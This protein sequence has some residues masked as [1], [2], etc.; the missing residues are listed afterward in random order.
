MGLFRLY[1]IP[2][3]MDP[4]LGT[5]VRYAADEL[6]AIVTLESQRARAVVVGE[7]LGTVEE[8]VRERLATHRLLSYR[9]LWF[10]ADPPAR[11]PE[12][13]LAAV[14]THDLPTVAG[15]WSGADLRTQQRLG[16]RPNE[17]GLREIA[18][19]LRAMTGLPERAQV[20]EVIVR[21]HQLLAEA[22]SV[23]VTA[24]LEDA[25]AVEERPNMPST[26]AEWPNWSLALPTPLED[27]ETQPLTQAVADTLRRR[28]SPQGRTRGSMGAP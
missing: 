14:T 25:L 5:Y 6:L 24:T 15:L 8:E 19:R 13:A 12:L 23:V 17:A 21:A 3:G 28:S 16:L 27:L 2:Q 11:Y 10:E 1:W 20:H 4:S 22:P 18:E 9:L 26:T 7:D